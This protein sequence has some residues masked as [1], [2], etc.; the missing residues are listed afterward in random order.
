MYEFTTF[1]TW[2]VFFIFFFGYFILEVGA[3]CA[4][5]RVSDR[6]FF[7]SA[8]STIVFQCVGFLALWGSSACAADA[9]SRIQLTVSVD[10]C[11]L[12]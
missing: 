2:R 6:Y 5:L 1:C 10:F 9:T 8:I 12:R 7:D 3:Q 4:P 11:F